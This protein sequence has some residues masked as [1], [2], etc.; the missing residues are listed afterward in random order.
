MSQPEVQWTFQPCVSCQA[1]IVWDDTPRP[2]C[3]AC[4]RSQHA[5]MLT[6]LRS[7]VRGKLI[8]ARARALLSSMEPQS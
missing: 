7:A 5:A 4:I 2:M 3:E 1:G 6:L 8:V